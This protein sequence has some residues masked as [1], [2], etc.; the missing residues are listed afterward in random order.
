MKTLIPLLKRDEVKTDASAAGGGGEKT[1]QTQQSGQTDEKTTESTGY[2]IEDRYSKKDASQQTE[3][4]NKTDDK[5]DEKVA[6]EKSASGYGDDLEEVE[7]AGYNGDKAPETEKKADD[8]SKEADEYAELDVKE[9]DEVLAS[10]LKQF[11]K[12]NKLPKEAAQALVNMKKEEVKAFNEAI[13]KVTNEFKQKLANEK[14]AQGQKWYGE[15]KADKDFGGEN[16][17]HN[18]KKVDNVLEKFFPNIKN[19]LTKSKGMLPPSAMRDIL[20]LHKVLFSND[21]FVNGEQVKSEEDPIEARYSKT[22]V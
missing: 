11:A 14:R 12:D 20:N 9:L 1:Q 5:K 15:L 10:D 18:L 7:T 16:F 4:S 6:E 21:K 8:K 17:K 19:D 2:N 3:Q 22:K 13:D